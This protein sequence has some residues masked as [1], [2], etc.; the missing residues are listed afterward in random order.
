MKFWFGRKNEDKKPAAAPASEPAPV[1]APA[2]KPAPAVEPSAPKA[3][4][5]KAQS[6]QA[7]AATQAA[8][9][10]ASG[11]THPQ[12]NQKI[13]Y[14]E[15]MNGLY[16]A[17]LVLDNNGHIVDCNNRVT[18]VLGY[19]RDDLWDVP[20]S[21]VIKDM[22]PQIL[23]KMRTAL[24]D[25]HQVLINAKCTRKDGTVFSG[26]VGVGLVRLVRGENFLFTVRNIDKRVAEA[27]QKAREQ[28][29]TATAK[30]S[31]GAKKV[32]LKAVRKP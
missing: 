10:S 2:L 1:P 15:L 8:P 11:M 25:S 30:P 9:A 14:Y 23:D 3:A 20:I 27:M 22:R 26:E 7:P 17:A 18:H 6:P 13:L 19:E 21:S 29:A 28:M 5:P 31:T 24:L 16:D 4:A 32:V 12:P